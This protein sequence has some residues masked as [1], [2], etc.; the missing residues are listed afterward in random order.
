[1]PPRDA[2]VA[3]TEAPPRAVTAFITSC[4][5]VGHGNH[6]FII[7][8]GI[9]FAFET[10]EYMQLVNTPCFL[11]QIMLEP[12]LLWMKASCL[13]LP[14]QQKYLTPNVF[15]FILALPPSCSCTVAAARQTNHLC[16]YVLKSL[17]GGHAF[18]RTRSQSQSLCRRLWRGRLSYFQPLEDRIECR[19]CFT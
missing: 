3:I 4:R 12:K 7:L 1:M 15:V 9:C 2:I 18:H 11:H 16:K 17:S 19:P 8:T 14:R 13:F 5:E 6:L 10:S